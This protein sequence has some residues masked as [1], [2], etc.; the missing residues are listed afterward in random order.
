MIYPCDLCGE[1]DATG[2]GD[3][4]DYISSFFDLWHQ[5]SKEGKL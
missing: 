2:M 1:D 4:P 3:R 5:M